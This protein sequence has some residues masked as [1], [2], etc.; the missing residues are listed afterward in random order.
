MVSGK[1]VV[2]ICKTPKLK[3]KLKKI[4]KWEKKLEN[5]NGM[6]S[7]QTSLCGISSH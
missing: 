6:V 4:G 1:I 2:K 7:T 3:Q 5:K